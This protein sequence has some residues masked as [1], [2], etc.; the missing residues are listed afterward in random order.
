MTAAAVVF[1]GTKAVDAESTSG[2][3][4]GNADGD[5]FVE[6]SGSVGAK[7]SS[8]LGRFY[9]LSVAGG[10][11]NFSS[12]GGNEGEHIWAWM[13]SLTP[14]DS[15]RI[16][17]VDDLATDSIGEWD[18]GP[19]AG[20]ALGF[21][22]YVINPEA[23]FS[24]IVT[25]GSG[26][27]TTTGNPAQL[28]GVDGF[29][30]ALNQTTT[31]M[32]NF[33]NAL[34]DAI[35]VGLGYRLTLG[36]AGSTEGAFT[37]FITYENNVSNK[38][39]G[40]NSR[41]G[42]LFPLCKIFIGADTGSTNTEFIDAGFTVVWPD[43]NVAT[44]FYALVLEQG[45]GTTDVTLS[46]GVFSSE[47]DPVLLD[48]AGVNS[49][50]FT[51]ISANTQAGGI[52]L[53][54]AVTWSGGT[55]TNCGPID[56]GGQPTLAT[57]TIIDPEGISS[58]SSDAA[59]MII[60]A[61]NEVANVSDIVF[62][63]A[64][65]GGTTQD[66]AIEINISGAGPHTL[67]FDNIVFQNRVSGSVDLH[68]LDQGADRTYTI[69]V[70]N[71]GSTPTFTKD[72]GTDTVNI[73]NTVTL[74]LKNVNSGAQC[75]IYAVDDD[76]QL[77]NETAAGGDVTESYSGSFPRDV[78]IRVRDSSGSPKYKPYVASGQI[79]SGTGLTV[80]VDQILDPIAV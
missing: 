16:I 41:A 8:A 58:V 61:A 44:D 74:T 13:A 72:R 68:F 55:L 59:A 28:S 49:V 67:D 39:G 31:I 64:G 46:N 12:G 69:N 79:V 1:V 77:M 76:T 5:V 80:S 32:G 47:A 42:V 6:G 57:L 2:W 50:S 75:A 23:D 70:L 36:D 43:A 9:D 25:A 18:V 20:Y 48:L 26:S 51:N 29:G 15:H 56:L 3:N 40:L 78:I 73:V 30:G 53:D 17:V 37:D 66:A 38:F 71:G 63:G 14:T 34:V 11:Y 33:N 21:A 60:N 65:L 10:P 24:R 7:T 45:T 22:N 62:D 4:T 54:S 19:A 35:S 27:W 52:L